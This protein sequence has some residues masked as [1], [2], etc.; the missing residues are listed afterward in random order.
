MKP[1]IILEP[2]AGRGGG[3][4]PG[5]PGGPMP[6]PAPMMGGP[7]MG[8]GPMMVPGKLLYYVSNMLTN[9]HL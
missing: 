7:M 5:P 9:S 6:G 3:P 1:C 4:M 2:P 8:P